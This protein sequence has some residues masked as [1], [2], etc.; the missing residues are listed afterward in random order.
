MIS[1]NVAVLAAM[2]SV[3]DDS[4]GVD[5]SDGRSITVP[6]AWFPRLA[7]GSQAERAK[8]RLIGKGSGIHWPDLDEDVSVES[9]LAGRMSEESPESLERWLEDRKHG[10]SRRRRASVGANLPR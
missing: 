10:K 7:H 1:S 2:V 5:L 6:I 4:L 8:W 9:L 3:N